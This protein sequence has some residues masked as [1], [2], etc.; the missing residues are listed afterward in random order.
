MHP[1]KSKNEQGPNLNNRN[2]NSKVTSHSADP[3]SMSLLTLLF[4]LPSQLLKI[5]FELKVL[6]VPLKRD[7]RLFPGR[8][9]QPQGFEGILRA[10]IVRWLCKRDAGCIRFA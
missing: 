5:P 8:T 7:L 6:K 1:N 9:K 4:H 2:C 3:Q 10:S